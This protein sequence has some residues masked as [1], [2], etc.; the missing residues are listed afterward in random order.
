MATIELRQVEKRFGNFQAVKPLDLTIQD[1]EFIVLLGPSG[2]GKTTTLR[3]ISGLEAVSGGTI[4]LN[5][6]NVTWLHPSERDIAFVFQFY[7]L[8]PHLTARQ[9]I[10]F[11]LQAQG[12]SRERIEER[13]YEVAKL[14]R[15]EHLLGAH[16]GQLSG[17]DQQRVALARAL[18]RRPA[19]F[20]MDEPLGALDADF[21]ESMRAEIKR[22]HVLQHATTIYVTHDQIEA[23]AMGDRI[24][25]MSDAKI[26]QI[27]TPSEVYNKP[28]NLFVAR[29]IGSPGMNL[30]NGNYASGVIKMAGLDNRYELPQNWKGA[31]ENDIKGEDGVVVGFRPE[32]AQ[33]NDGGQLVGKVYAT[34]MQGSS[35]VLH[36]TINEDEIIHIRTDRLIHYPIDTL[37]HFDINPQ[38]VRF[39]NPKTE[40]AIELEVTQ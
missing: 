16:P 19:A 29:F 3:M 13:I 31:L 18:V 34:E 9:N 21:R 15:I 10:A 17:G 6:R 22:L 40:L 11:P 39:F 4:S 30:V 24:V 36:L 14:L 37:V 25:V 23:M 1:G 38:M 35:A 2:C 7:A 28:A 26:Q 5:G 27:G 32:A 20:L 8:Y 33:I 12:E